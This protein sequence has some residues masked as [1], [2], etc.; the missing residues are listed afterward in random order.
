VADVSKVLDMKN[1]EG[2]GTFFERFLQEKGQT[3]GSLKGQTNGSLS[4][5]VENYTSG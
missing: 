3:N 5:H 2:I 4:E 1:H